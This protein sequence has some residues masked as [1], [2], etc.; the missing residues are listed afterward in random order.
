MGLFDIF[1][2]KPEP[3]PKPK[4]R[5]LPLRGGGMPPHPA[6]QAENHFIVI[7]LDS[8]RYDSFMEAAPKTITKLSGGKVEKR[9][10]YASWTAPSHYNL[11][12]GLFPHTSP[13]HVY[14]SEYYKEDFYNYNARLG[15]GS[16]KIDFGEMVPGLWLPEFLRNKMGYHTGARVS[17][18][19]LNPKTGVNRFFDSFQ[20]MD[21]HNDMAAML[22]TL[23]FDS[24]RPSF[25]MLNVG[26]THYPYAKPNEDSSMWPRISGVNGVFKK[27]NAQIDENDPD[28][29]EEFQFFDQDKMDQLKERQIDTVR[30]LDGVFEQLYDMVPENT[31][32]IVTADHGECFGEGGYFGHGPIMHEKT[33]EVPYLEGKLR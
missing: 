21:S 12:T 7:T 23:K 18:P 26:E 2:A 13:Q 22:P 4:P 20:L 33:F 5:P 19:V 27:M 28:F 8:C 3:G 30:Y 25:Y 15:A 16:K 6:P 9:Y 14:A 10:T 31:Y 1:K 32:I 24:E 29:K 11:L 17:L